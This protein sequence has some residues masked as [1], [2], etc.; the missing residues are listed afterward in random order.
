M[1][2]GLHA[3]LP[4]PPYTIPNLTEYPDKYYLQSNPFVP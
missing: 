3:Q 1:T 2:P 4:L